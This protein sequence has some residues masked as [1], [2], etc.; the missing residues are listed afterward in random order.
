V[1]RLV[2][3]SNRLWHCTVYNEVRSAPPETAPALEVDW[4]PTFA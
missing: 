2:K 4:T 1:I 3:C